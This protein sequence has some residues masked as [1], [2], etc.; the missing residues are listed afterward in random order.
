MSVGQA[1]YDQM[2][3][4]AEKALVQIS[5]HRKPLGFQCSACQACGQVYEKNFS[6]GMSEVVCLACGLRK[7]YSWQWHGS[8]DPDACLVCDIALFR[9]YTV[10]GGM[11]KA[12]ALCVRDGMISPPSGNGQV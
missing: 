2:I 10:G 8:D 9:H 4:P 12:C 5:W 3:T 1:L 6:G 11:V 7:V